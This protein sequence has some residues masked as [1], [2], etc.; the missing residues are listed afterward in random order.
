M[1]EQRADVRNALIKEGKL[2]V[3]A[4]KQV[5]DDRLNEAIAAFQ[6]QFKAPGK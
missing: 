5:D 4:Q 3:N 1:R 6:H 2:R